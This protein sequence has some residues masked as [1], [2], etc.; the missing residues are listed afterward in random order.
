ML[1]ICW[2]PRNDARHCCRDERGKERTLGALYTLY[3]LALFMGDKQYGVV[4]AVDAAEELIARAA[5]RAAQIRHAA[6]HAV[7][8]QREAAQPQQPA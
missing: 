2:S 7:L 4:P 5:R 1:D 8:A 6:D 3:A